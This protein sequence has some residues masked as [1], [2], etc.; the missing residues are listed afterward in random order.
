MASVAA[1]QPV[2][3]RLLRDAAGAGE[4]E[5]GKGS[6]FRPAHFA[7]DAIDR[8]RREHAGILEF[9]EQLPIRDRIDEVHHGAPRL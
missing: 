3:P 8:V 9:R 7:V 4:K 1:D 6:G 5:F 2:Q